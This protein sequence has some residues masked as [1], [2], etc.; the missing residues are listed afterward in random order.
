LP[1]RLAL[2]LLGLAPLGCILGG[3][4]GGID[5]THT[6][7]SQDSR[8]QF[9]I[10]HYTDLDLAGSLEK[11]S[12]GN[13]SSHYLIGDGP[14]PTIYQ[15]VDESRRAWHAGESSWQ[16][17]TALNASSIG[18]EIV[19][20][21]NHDDPAAP[22]ADYPPLQIDRV[23]A[24]VRDLAQRHGVK[25]HRI[26][27][28]GEVQPQTK[29]DPGPRFPWR[30]LEGEGLIPWPDPAQVA[31][32]QP[33]FAAAPPDATWFQEKLAAHGF[34]ITRSGLFDE[35][36]RRVLANFQMRYHPSRYDG[37]ADPQTAALLEVVTTPGGLLL[38][39]PEGLRPY[40]PE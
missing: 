12:R 8:V 14:S 11:L 5:R 28:H 19:N 3:P 10:L 33:R 15:L 29:Q 31:A 36:T 27:G 26:V 38:R 4:P 16:G 39:G 23:V 22:Y 32:Q 30:R 9:I 20:P 7:V 40:R 21:G 1:A 17:R 13:V 24:L 35:P 34:A 37:E 25:P 18:I 2:L 6:A